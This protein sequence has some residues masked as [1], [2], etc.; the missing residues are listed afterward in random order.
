MRRVLGALA[1]MVVGLLLTWLCLYVFSNVS[2]STSSVSTGCGD[3]EHCSS[4]WWVG[5]AHLSLLLLPSLACTI[6][7]YRSVSN[8][9]PKWR[10]IATFGSV[11]IATAGAAAVLY[12]A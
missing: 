1:G 4:S 6:S 10:V 9:W 3:A 7:G 5:P 2:V 8:C 12:L 11:A